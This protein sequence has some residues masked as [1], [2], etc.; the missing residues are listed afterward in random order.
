M[1]PTQHIAPGLLD[2]RALFTDPFYDRFTLRTAPRPLSLAPGIEKDYLFPTFYGDVT[3][4]MAIFLCPYDRAAALMPHPRMRPVRLTRGCAAVAFSCYI[5][6]QVL[7]VPPYNEIAMT[8]PV[9][10]DP[11]LSVPVLPL[12]T[13]WFKNFGYYVFSMPVTS[14]ENQIRGQ[15]IWGLPKVVQEIDISEAAGECVTTAMEEDGTPYFTLRVPTSGTPADFDVRS[16]LYTRLG[17]RLLQSE[18]AF[19]A[20]F[21]VTK[22]PAVLRK[23][24]A[25]PPNPVLILGD[26]PSGRVLRDLALEP[27]PFQ[28]RFARG[29]ASCFDLPNPEYRAPFDFAGR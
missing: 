16:N 6:N 10:V 27:Q 20:R 22:Y 29:M 1:Q 14:L 12:V 21:Q 7:G 26:T 24:A 9:Q 28:F 11:R 5:Y 13:P 17:D 15:E 18:T 19:K 25:P 4:A 23:A 8:I 2:N 3:C